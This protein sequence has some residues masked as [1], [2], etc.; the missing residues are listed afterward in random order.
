M[1][2]TAIAMNSMKPIAGWP[3]KSVNFSCTPIHAPRMVGSIEIASSR[4]VLRRTRFWAGA[5]V[6]DAVMI[7]VGCILPP[8]NV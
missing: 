6:L 4:Y 7:G 5:S 2:P 3:G 8:R 1:K